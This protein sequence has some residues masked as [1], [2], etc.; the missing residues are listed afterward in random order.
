MSVMYAIG[1][2][3]DEE[4]VGVVIIGRPTARALDDGKTLEV[5]RTCTDGS[6]NANSFLYGAAARVAKNL[7]YDKLVTYTLADES[8]ASLRASGWSVVADL[9]PRSGWDTP[10]RPRTDVTLW[11]EKKIPTAVRKFRW[12]LAL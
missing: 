4:L 2:E 5:T 10:S 3:S 7:G 6:K 12:E 9:A 11:G 8:G 1:A